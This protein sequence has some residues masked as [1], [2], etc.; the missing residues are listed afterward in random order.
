MRSVLEGCQRFDISNVLRIP[1]SILIF[2][3]PS[4]ALPFGLR[5]PGI[6]LLLA[7]S[8]L[9][10]AVAHMGFCIHILPALKSKPSFSREVIN[11]LIS[12]GGWITVANFLNPLLIYIDR[13]LIGSILS[14]AMVGYYTAH[15]KRS[16]SYG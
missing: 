15:S 5:L 7:I 3:I 4:L 9:V 10:F 14:V 1:S 6:V 13:F 16:R 8:R 2:V 11:P 12:F